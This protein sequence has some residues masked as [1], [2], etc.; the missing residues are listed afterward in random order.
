MV[1]N[2]HSAKTVK[3][4]LG[5]RPTLEPRR[6]KCLAICLSLWLLSVSFGFDRSLSAR[7]GDTKPT[8]A[9]KSLSTTD[10]DDKVGGKKIKPD[11]FK[12]VDD[13]TRLTVLALV[14]C[15]LGAIALLALIVV[16]ARRIRKMTRS[17]LLKSKYD[18]LELLREKYRR[19]VEGLDT[20]P[21]PSR[22]NRR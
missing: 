7:A 9:E 11:Q 8:A 20:P 15:V 14:L 17:P 3:L 19:E 22:E 5:S 13:L 1:V 21:P 6:T 16:G 2:L 18:E 10:A 12:E 4:L